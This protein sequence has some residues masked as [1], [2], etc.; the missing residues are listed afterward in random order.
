MTKWFGEPW[1]APCCADEDD[2]VPVP[3]G[4]MCGT[5]RQMINLHD[6]GLVIPHLSAWAYAPPS[7]VARSGQ[8]SLAASE[9]PHHL[10]CFLRSIGVD[11]L[12]S[13]L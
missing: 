7:A 4:Q 12:R 13:G 5:C 1:D 11:D 2:R 6:R 8:R 3:Y 9:R 10:V